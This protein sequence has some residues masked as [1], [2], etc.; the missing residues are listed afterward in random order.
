MHSALPNVAVF[1]V[2]VAL[3]RISVPLLYTPPPSPYLLAPVSPIAS[4]SVMLEPVIMSFP[5]VSTYTPPPPSMSDISAIPPLS[6][7]FSSVSVLP[8]FTLKM[9]CFGLLPVSLFASITADDAPVALLIVRFLLI[10]I[11][12]LLPVPLVAFI[13]PS[14]KMTA[15]SGAFLTARARSFHVAEFCRVDW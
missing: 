14:M 6:V 3:V 7:R 1:P 15:L 5:L 13:S 8:L 2:R 9:R 11:S 4:Q 12:P 10:T